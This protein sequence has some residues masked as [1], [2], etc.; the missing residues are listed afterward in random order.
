MKPPLKFSIYAILYAATEGIWEQEIYRSLKHHY[1]KRA[2]S[3][4]RSILLEMQNK[5]WTNEINSIIYDNTILRKY[6]LQERH[7]EFV[8]YQLSPLTILHELGLDP[9]SFQQK[10][11][12]I[13]G[14]TVAGR[15]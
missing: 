10:E 12:V 5:S 15:T 14:N 9:R 3:K 13:N 7:R 8:E 1:N 4:I 2:L 11:D 6:Q